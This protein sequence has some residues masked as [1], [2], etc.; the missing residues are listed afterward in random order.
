MRC[1]GLSPL[2][3]EVERAEVWRVLQVE[4]QVCGYKDRRPRVEE[5][6]KTERHKN[7]CSKNRLN[8]RQK[9]ESRP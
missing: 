3:R 2:Q 7:I 8:M 5:E 6:K 1:S 4:G 9:A